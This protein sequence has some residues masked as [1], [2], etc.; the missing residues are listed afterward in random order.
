MPVY[1]ITEEDFEPLDR[2]SFEAERLLE[3]GDMQRRLR[4]SPEILEEG[5]YILAEEY[6]DW[7]ESNRRIDLLALDNKGRL[8]VIEL[9][10]SDTDSLMDLQAIRY[11]AMVA[12]MTSRQAVD[13]HSQYLVNRRLDGTEAESRIREHLPG[14]DEDLAITSD[15]PR[16]FLVSASFSKELTTSVMWLNRTGMDIT[17]VKLQP[18]RSKDGLFLE[19]SQVIPIPEAADYLIRL[20]NREEEAHQHQVESSIVRTSAGAERFKEAIESVHDSQ[21]EMLTHL[22]DMA[23]SLQASGLAELSTRSGSYNTVLRVR[24]PGSNRGLINVFKNESGWGYLQFNVSLFNRRAPNAKARLE[25]T[26]GTV[27]RTLWELPDGFQEILSDAYR[28]ANGQPDPGP[29]IEHSPESDP[30]EDLV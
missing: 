27:K 21:K 25:E 15:T 3:R 1:K 30:P 11:A 20:R 9:K 29:A 14:D 12:D 22:Y 6:G 13:A 24:F 10:R 28:E 8:V 19:S 23:L 17:C 2:T 16:I 4:D 18:Y 7:E 26:I 5:L